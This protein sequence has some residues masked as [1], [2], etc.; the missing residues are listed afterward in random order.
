[1]LPTRPLHR[2]GHT[3]HPH[4]CSQW[5]PVFAKPLPSG[6]P[7]IPKSEERSV[8]YRQL[9]LRNQRNPGEENYPVPGLEGRGA[10]LPRVPIIAFRFWREE[11]QGLRSAQ[12]QRRGLPRRAP[13]HPSPRPSGGG[14]FG[15]RAPAHLRA[16][17]PALPRAPAPGL[18]RLRVGARH[19]GGGD[20][21]SGSSGG[22]LE[23]A[24]SALSGPTALTPA[25]GPAAHPRL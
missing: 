6:P 25:R 15:A 24:P 21:G 1:M 20:G 13:A 5:V 14:M 17:P 19:K 9:G 12:A 18:R 23:A 7:R 8:V 4:C 16:P 3:V 22:A 11:P 10:A 2:S